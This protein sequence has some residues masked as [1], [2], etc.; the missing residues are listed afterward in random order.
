MLVVTR[1]RGE[2]VFVAPDIE[3]VVVD[4]RQDRVRLGIVAPSG[5]KILR[6]ELVQKEAA[7]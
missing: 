2:R 7:K 3:V 6:E 4:I 1:K 5:T